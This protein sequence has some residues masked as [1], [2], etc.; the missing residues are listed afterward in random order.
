MEGTEA[1]AQ[2]AE[3]PKGS[4]SQEEAVTLPTHALVS[5][6]SAVDAIWALAERKWEGVLDDE[7]IWLVPKAQICVTTQGDFKKLA[8]SV[9]LEALGIK[10][11]PVDLLVPNKSCCSRGKL[12]R[13][14]VWS[15][16]FPPH[17]FVRV[18]QRVFVSTPYFAVLQLAM[19]CR[20]SRLQR[21]EAAES[22]AEDARIRAELGIPGRGSSVSELLRWGNIARFARAA[23]VLTDFMGTYRYVPAMTPEDAPSVS[24]HT[25]PLISPEA[26]AEYLVK[27]GSS[28][29]IERARAVAAAAF[30]GAA[31]P[32]ETALALL[33]TLPTHMGG[34]GLPRPNL[35][36]EIDV[37]PEQRPVVSQAHITPDL[38]WPNDRVA[39]EY[40]GWE[41]H[42][43]AGP[44]KVAGDM[45]RIN[46]LSALGWTGFQVT[47]N[48][49]KT[50]AGISLLARQIAHALGIALKEP[51]DLELVWRTRL[52]ALLLPDEKNVG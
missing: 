46:S 51:T 16:F 19:A 4:N 38:C 45:T 40:Y 25:K 50:L 48:N 5:H 21:L 35:N 29:G 52:L 41:E 24:Y 2:D 43:C 22:A 37:N 23:Q 39:V 49:V 34:F 10:G 7:S 28:R 32:M 42:F 27:M 33:L 26:F 17:S 3:I 20:V 36:W 47:F 18:H 15:D 13:F 12:A 11:T 6:E 30:A 31:S 14:H 44:N 1:A 9:D 8:A